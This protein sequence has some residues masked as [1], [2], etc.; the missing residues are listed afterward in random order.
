ME[1]FNSI[2]PADKEPAASDA[3]VEQPQRQQA[4]FE[5]HLGDARSAGPI[6]P[7]RELYD[8]SEEDDRLIQA[9]SAA[10]LER[11]LPLGPTTVSIYDRRLRKL[12]E[13]LRGSG[14]SMAGLDDDALLGYAKK[15]LPTD[16]VIAPALLM[17]SR[18]RKPGDA[19]AWSTRTH[20]RPS[21]EDERLIRKAAEAGFGRKI[22]AKTAENYA[23]SLRKLAAA[24]RPL[25]I[26]KL[27]DDALLGHADTLCRD[28]KNL[29]IAL[30]GL[31]HYRAITGQA[32]LGGRGVSSSPPTQPATRSFM[33]LLDQHPFGNAADQGSRR[34]GNSKAAQ[35][36]HEMGLAA[37][38]AIQSATQDVPFDGAER[39][40]ELPASGFNAPL[41]WQ[42]MRGPACS[43]VQ[44]F[45]Q[46]AL[47]DAADR[48]GLLP[49]I[50]FDAGELWPTTSSVPH[51][52][53]QSVPQEA[54]F[55]AVD[56]EGLEAAA[57][58]NAPVPW[59][60]MSSVV[61]SPVQS[62]AQEELFG[63]ADRGGLLPSAPLN[64]PVFWPR[65]SSVAPLPVQNVAQEALFDPAIRQPSAQK[66]NPAPE[67]DFG[68]MMNRDAAAPA[69]ID[70][71]FSTA[72]E[73]FDASFAVPETFS[74]GTQPAPDMLRSKLSRWG[75]LPDAAQ[76][77]KTY[78]IHGERYTAVLGPRGRADVQLIHLR[79]PAAGDTF[80]VSFAVPKDFSHRTQLAPD[81][82][83]STLGK[84]DFLPNAEYPLINYEIGGERYTAVLGPRGS[85][86][87]QLIH[88]PKFASRSEAAPVTPAAPPHT[89]DGHA[90]GFE[91][92]SRFEWPAPHLQLP[93]G[94]P[95]S[96]QPALPQVPELGA[97]FGQDW[98][99]GPR[100]ASPL[101]I[102]MLQNRGVL[103][104]QRV[105]MTC[106]LIH[107]EPYTAESL[108]GG[109]VVLFHRPQFG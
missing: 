23:S 90:S 64:P 54:L 66:P 96:G 99:H 7:H 43:P 68:R 91:R 87:V 44:S 80:D 93:T 72:G 19:I 52:P 3:T 103:P 28:D 102:D 71:T 34:A 67:E 35:V 2:N 69:T 39:S 1:Q 94:V 47:F 21:N 107:G 98:R 105:P 9:A 33:Q 100:E 30:N 83:L 48:E 81:V 82:M 89:Y 10:A 77:V 97:L 50:S 26:A 46:E 25:S 75:L 65:M 74:H 84:W 55:D 38:S 109:R 22:D 79:S 13:L 62:V 18:Y 45:A 106:F 36:S 63:A 11:G 61:H 49:A 15:L 88:H 20:Y 41:L 104:N 31:R 101:E 59:P 8:V 17:V 24:L 70:S 58:F 85:N 27:S 6:Y 14:E 51:S 92:P 37:H 76:R 56:R 95:L 86:D 32:N 12:A 53:G 73:S 40:G 42:G 4:D 60:T 78:D 5:Q 29:I 57:P 16:K 108:P